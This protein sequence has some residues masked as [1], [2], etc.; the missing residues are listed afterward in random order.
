MLFVFFKCSLRD[1]PIVRG[2]KTHKTKIPELS[3][4]ISSW[5]TNLW[6]YLDI[7]ISEKF[8]GR[9]AVRSCPQS[10][11]KDFENACTQWFIS[12]SGGLFFTC[13]HIMDLH[14]SYKS[15]WPSVFCILL[16]PF[17][18]PF[19]VMLWAESWLLIPCKRLMSVSWSA[20]NWPW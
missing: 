16:Q 20:N 5:R 17:L 14:Q 9:D 19:L 13:G 15:P 10:T 2:R 12:K 18:L 7:R 1:L 11:G 8:A 6:A 3:K 4:F